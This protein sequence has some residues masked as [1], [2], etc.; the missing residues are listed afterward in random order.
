MLGTRRIWAIATAVT[1]ALAAAW[2]AGETTRTVVLGRLEARAVEGVRLRQ[3][4]LASEIARFRLLPRALA[5]DQ[6]LVR[7]AS[8][9]SPQA[10]HALNRK[11][12]TLA[13]EFGASAIYV[14]DRNGA[15]FGASNWRRPDSFIGRNY[16][17]R[18][19]FADA[20]RNGNGQQF[21]LGTAS[22]KAGLYLATRAAGGSVAVV[23]LE[24]DRIEAQWRA[25][26]GITYVTDAQGVI[27]VTSRPEWRFAATAPIGPEVRDA[28]ER[29]TGVSAIQP[30]P[31][32]QSATNVIAP[33]GSDAS[34]LRATS[35]P[36]S[37][38]R[39]LNLAL[40]LAGAV[41]TAVRIA[42]GVALLVS[43]L[44]FATAAVLVERSR[45][46]RLRTV[47][48]ENA[49]AERTAEL[50]KEILDRTAAEDRAAALR[51]GLRQANRLA[52]LGQ[53][54]A[55]VAH[56]TAQPVAAIR[57]YATTTAM[58]IDRGA[59]TEARENLAIIERLA[60]R[61]GAITAH[62]RGFARK[63]V[64]GGV[65]TVLVAQAVE[66]A[67]LMLKEQLSRIA[68]VHPDLDPQ[69]AVRAEKVRLEQVLVILLQNAAEALADTDNPKVTLTVEQD[70][71]STSLVI[72]DNGP[73]LSPD[74][75]RRLFTP[76]ATSRAMGLGL[77]LV[78]A[79]E[80]VEEFGGSLV[81]IPSDAGA[82]FR[83]TL[84]GT[85]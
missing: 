10:L 27:L 20:L 52:T 58:L 80:I 71:A 83:I 32:V 2:I 74:I 28:E 1:L 45:Q 19:Y 8:S 65:E 25:A 53:V 69:L 26:Q 82:R 24:F 51:E 23:K 16:R 43:L 59:M 49:V 7:A 15:T 70:G 57:N 79:K 4:L 3:A 77:G 56:E 62:L 12:E 68:F 33:N 50:R 73:G 38:G 40:P 6:D 41:G 66:G 64:R 63:G 47:Q 31:F 72:T 35:A 29:L 14:I 34:Y 5:D 37:A 17:F 18:P 75:A 11:L 13:R 44:L 22:R 60:D 85:P 61:I 39:R 21:A 30:P 81:L 46:R 55:S 36:D 76:F 84:P 48:L 42:Q 54:T 67:R 9:K 78:I